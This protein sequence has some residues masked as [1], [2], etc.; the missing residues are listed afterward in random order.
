MSMNG[1]VLCLIC[2][3]SIAVLVECNT[4]RQCNSKHQ[5][6]YKSWWCYDKRI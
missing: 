3:E 5:E 2:S 1:K 6:K 4:A